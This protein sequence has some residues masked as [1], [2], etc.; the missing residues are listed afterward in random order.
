MKKF[1]ILTSVMLM[2]L[3]LKAQ[4]NVTV[5]DGQDWGYLSPIMGYFMN[6]EQR[7][8]VLYPSSMLADLQGQEISSLT[9][10]GMGEMGNVSFDATTQV[11]LSVMNS[12]D[13]T[14]DHMIYNANMTTVY[15]GNLSLQNGQMTISFAN[16]FTYPA[17]GGDLLVQFYSTN[18]NVVDDC[19]F[20]GVEDYDHSWIVVSDGY[21]SDSTEGDILPMVTFGLSS[22]ITC[23]TPSQLVM[24]DNGMHSIT[25]AWT[26]SGS[27][28]QWQYVYLTQPMNGNSTLTPNTVGST[29][30]TILNLTAGTEYY[31]YVRSICSADDQSNWRGPLVA[32]TAMCENPC[33]LDIWMADDYADSWDDSYLRFV[34]YGIETRVAIHNGMDE[35]EVQIGFCPTDSVRLYWHSDSYYDDEVSFELMAGDQVLYSCMQCEPTDGELLLTYL[36]SCGNNDDDDDDDNDTIVCLKPIQLSAYIM[37][38][39]GSEY[40][41]VFNWQPQGEESQWEIVAEIN[42]SDIEGTITIDTIV[43]TNTF[44]IYITEGASVDVFFKVRAY[45]SEDNQSAWETY[46]LFY[47]PVDIDEAV[48]DNGIAIYPNPAKDHATIDLAGMTGAVTIDVIDIQGRTI[49]SQQASC[50]DHSHVRLNL[51][52]LSKGIYMVRVSNNAIS[53]SQRIVIGD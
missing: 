52:G 5:A 43:S 38:N 26:E 36:P 31:I 19:E 51:E 25:F 15:T 17:N 37:D 4:S 32:R 2:A 39:N 23:P 46:I 8:Q 22:T 18:G 16:S 10:Y 3:G 20:I 29:T 53:K 35:E 12:I 24:T 11:S 41:A 1:F 27:A 49:L 21:S 13:A 14:L 45:C 40:A 28:S 44:S 50:E 33:P 34:Q 6:L 47:Q 9:F 30:A 42:R 7:T 48:A